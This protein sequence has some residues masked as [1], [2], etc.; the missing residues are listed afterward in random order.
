LGGRENRIGRGETPLGWTRTGTLVTLASRGGVLRARSASGHLERTIAMHTYNQVFDRAG[1]ALL[2]MARG[3][4]ERFDGEHTQRLGRMARYSLSGRESIAPLGAVVVLRDS[5]RL[6]A[7][8]RDGS[9][10]SSTTL[11]HAKAQGDTVPGALAAEGAGTVAF[12]ASSGNTAYGSKGLERVYLLRPH[13]SA[14]QPIY[15][16]RVH[17]AVCERMAELAWRGSW[18]LYSASEGYAA[19]VNTADPASSID[20]SALI[21]RLPGMRG[22]VERFDARWSDPAAAGS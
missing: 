22:N 2:F 1:R 11:P 16:E 6:V 17:F 7:L 10:L 18:L 19:A 3:R 9:L 5:H 13:T 20:L 12:T 8:E 15:R 14:A 4:L 21:R